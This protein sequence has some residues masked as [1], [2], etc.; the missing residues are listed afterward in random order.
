MEA[1]DKTLM[2]TLLNEE[3]VDGTLPFGSTVAGVV[4]IV[5]VVY[6]NR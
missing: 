1:I 2:I 5:V 6:C 4:H 3:S